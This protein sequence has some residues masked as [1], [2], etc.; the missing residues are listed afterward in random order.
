MNVL[1]RSDPEHGLPENHKAGHVFLAVSWGSLP[2]GDVSLGLMTLKRENRYSMDSFTYGY[3]SLII[4]K[5]YILF[6]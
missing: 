2:D 1:G 6:V 5:F 4:L 3:S